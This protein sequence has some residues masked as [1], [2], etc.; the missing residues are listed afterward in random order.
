MKL[1]R[2]RQRL[3]LFHGLI[4]A[5]LLLLIQSDTFSSTFPSS[6]QAE[7]RPDI[8]IFYLY[9]M[10]WAQPGAYGGKLAPTPHMDNIA[11]NGVRFT[12]G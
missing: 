8:V 12:N 4:A 9:D 5:T 2:N 7:P 10:G 3:R 1:F 6:T 11:A